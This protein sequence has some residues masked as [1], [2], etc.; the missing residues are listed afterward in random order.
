ME[1]RNRMDASSLAP[2]GEATRRQLTDK[3]RLSRGAIRVLVIAAALVLS[4]RIPDFLTIGNVETI[5]AQAASLGLMSI[6]L[7]FVLLGGGIDLSIPAVMGLAAVVGATY[8][9]HGN[10][11]LGLVLMVG[12][13]GLAGIVNGYAVAYLRMA[14]FAVTFASFLVANALAIIA[15]KN[16]NSGALSP[17]FINALLATVAGIPFTVIGFIVVVFIVTLAARR[18]V[19]GRGLY[20]TGTNESTARI[21]GIRTRRILCSTYVLAG[22]FAGLAAIVLSGQEGSA[23][24]SFGSEQVIL[25]VVAACV[26]GGVSIDGGV[27]SPLGAAIGA[28]IIAA[29]SNGFV[30]LN[31]SNSTSLVI[32][33]ALIVVVVTADK[34]S[35]ARGLVQAK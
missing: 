27:G 30:L 12:I 31:V 13:G 26:V 17:A 4:S 19:F 32:E 3:L 7:S 28:V 21:A 25:E 16:V 1:I 8:M 34:L 2:S 29:M 33:G 15:T 22:L 24:P 6:G 9:V 10:L 11:V 20:A 23:S 5:G 18:T 35:R 14:P